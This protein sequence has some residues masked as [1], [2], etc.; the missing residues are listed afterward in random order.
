VR[1]TQ[2]FYM[3]IYPVTKGQFAKFVED[4]KYQTEAEK[5]GE[6]MTWRN[7]GFEQNEH[8]PVVMVT[9]NEAVK[10]CEWLSEKEKH[11]YRLPTEAEWEYACRAG[12]PT[13]YFF[14]NDPAMLHE[15]AWFGGDEEKKKQT[16]PIAGKQPNPW[17]LEDMCGNVRQWCRDG[18]RTYT[19]KSEEDP[20]GPEMT[21]AER[22]IRGGDF[23]SPAK[24]CR[25]A[26]RMQ[27]KPSQRTNQIGF[28]VVREGDPPAPK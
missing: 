18:M 21:G 5:A 8:D 11:P 27:G 4:R 15:Y 7:P 14:G 19:E 28:R 12:T 9:W 16:H 13:A 26:A 25:S 22:A 23:N 10:F 3:S 20:T 6:S 2:A 17:S 24:D 1:I